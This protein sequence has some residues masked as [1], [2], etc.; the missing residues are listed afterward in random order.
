MATLVVIRGLPASGKSTKARAWVAEDPERRARI[1]RDDI[2]TQLH[3][4]VFVK[5]D[6]EHPGTER[7]VQVARDAQITALLKLGVDVVSD[8]TNLPSRT[9]RDL[10]KLA[11]AAGAGFE[12]WDLTDVPYDTCMARNAQREGR[13]RVPDERM[14]DMYQ[15]FVRGKTY[16]LPLREEPDGTAD[17][18]APYTPPVGAPTAI[19]VDLDG[20]AALM[21]DRGPYDWARV[22]DDA[23]N[24]PV[25]EAVLAMLARGHKVVFL[26]GRDEVCR[27]DTEKWLTRHFPET[28]TLAALHGPDVSELFMRPAGDQR[29]DSIVKAELFDQHIRDQY[30]V[31]S[32]FDDRDQVVRMWRSLGLTVFQV[33]EGNF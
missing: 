28:A 20:T 12:V 30:R 4:S 19:L 8:D 31:V 10:R 18:F 14:L 22:G 7:A 21:G 16:P 23:V 6:D 3:D 27:P 5:R 17:T 24:E 9:V 2:R 32:V 1:N 29:K 15:R 25:R 33:A 11:V 13:A 26:S